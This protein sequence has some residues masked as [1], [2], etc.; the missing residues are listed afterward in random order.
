MSRRLSLCFAVLIGLVLSPCLP[1][2]ASTPTIQ[3][4]E[5]RENPSKDDVVSYIKAIRKAFADQHARDF[6]SSAKKGQASSPTRINLRQATAKLTQIPAA[7]V[8][9]LLEQAR[10]A[11][12]DHD[13]FS[14]AAVTAINGRDDFGDELKEPILRCLSDLPELGRTVLMRGWQ[15]GSEA[16]ILKIAAGVE[17]FAIPSFVSLV[18]QID[19]PEAR[20]IL[21][22]LLTK[23]GARMMAASYRIVSRLD[24]DWLNWTDI[25]AK[26]WRVAKAEEGSGLF[27]YAP[28]A[29]KYGITE[30]LVLM[31][32]KLNGAPA[33]YEREDVFVRE[34][35]R[36]ALRLLVESE[37][38]DEKALVKFVLDNRS[39]MIFDSTDGKYKLP[40]KPATP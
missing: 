14:V 37:D 26:G 10:S 16:R 34:E 19:S 6:S 15:K 2:A 8:N 13:G 22:G 27:S 28:I 23:G 5:L 12:E 21:P 35:C 7:Y 32:K 33:P 25:A 39:N 24:I 3:D 9:L 1:Y 18:A 38:S 20:K 17:G 36:K 30:A 29:A 4:I 31:A 40:K 11:E